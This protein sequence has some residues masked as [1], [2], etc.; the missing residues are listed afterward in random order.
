MSMVTAPGVELR[1]IHREMAAL[2]A[3]P[4]AQIVRAPADVVS[5]QWDTKE[6]EVLIRFV[7]L[8]LVSKAVFKSSGVVIMEMDLVDLINAW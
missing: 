4:G 1:H 2:I 7:K 3:L 6:M 8:L 5:V